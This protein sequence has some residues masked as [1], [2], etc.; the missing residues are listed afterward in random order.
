MW[1]QWIGIKIKN[2]IKLH[3]ALVLFHLDFLS[4]MLKLRAY[5]HSRICPHVRSSFDRI[6][7]VA[8]TNRALMTNRH[9]NCMFNTF[10]MNCDFN[11]VQSFQMMLQ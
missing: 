11:W 8:Q 9:Y 4:V 6:F 10:K 2:L 5:E 7:V 1:K 3:L